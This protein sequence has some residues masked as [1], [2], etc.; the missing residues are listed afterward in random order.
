MSYVINL[1]KRDRK[2][3]TKRREY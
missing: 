3:S 2:D 1:E